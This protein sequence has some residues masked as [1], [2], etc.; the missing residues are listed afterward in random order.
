MHHGTC[1]THVP[2]CM[3]GSLTSSFLWSRWRGKRSRHT[4]RRHNPQFYV[5]GKRPM[6]RYVHDNVM[7]WTHF[8]RDSF[9]VTTIHL[10]LMQGIGVY[11]LLV[12]LSFWTNCGLIGNL[13][14]H[15][16]HITL[17][18]WHRYIAMSDLHFV[19]LIQWDFLYH[20][21]VCKLIPSK[22][23]TDSRRAKPWHHYN[24]FYSYVIYIPV[25]HSCGLYSLWYMSINL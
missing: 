19:A 23:S 25:S 20:R 3:L 16:A 18:H 4:R 10:P 7:T 22:P 8:P 21:A 24:S 12:S 14:R 17:L 9:F 5:S 11:L 15:D 13:I 1:V 6:A 2:W